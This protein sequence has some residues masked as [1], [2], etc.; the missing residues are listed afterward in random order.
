MIVKALVRDAL[1]SLLHGLGLSRLDKIGRG[2]LLILTFHRVLPESLRAQYPLPGL[3]VTPDELRWILASLLPHFELRTVSEAVREFG[4]S[5]SHRSL[6]A[7]TFDDGQLDNLEHAAPVL[8]SLGARAT[9]Y[10]P[11]DYIGASQLLWHDRAA[12]AWQRSSLERRTQTLERSQSLRLDHGA[13][14]YAFLEALKQLAPEQREELVNELDAAAGE[15]TPDWARLMT[16]EEVRELQA[17]G[18]EIG[19]HSCTH[20]L[21]PQL[22]SSEQMNELA[23][24]MQILEQRLGMKPQSM[25]YPNGSYDA[26]SMQLSQQVG[27]ENAVTTRWGINDVGRSRFELLRCDMDAR[28]LQSRTGALARSR[29]AMRLA[30]FQPGLRA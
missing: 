28:R 16:W 11:T 24:S 3:V 10:L 29:L 17:Q 8:R 4:P 23:G 12:F 20:A 25:C 9:F 5:T 7:I 21:L 26:T 14:V 15:R 6:L 27:Y 2:K 30:G 1:A 13:S 19:S 18:H 22:S